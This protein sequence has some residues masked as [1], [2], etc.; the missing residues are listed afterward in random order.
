MSA[1]H[2]VKVVSLAVNLPGPL[3]VSRLAEFGASVIKVEPPQGDPLAQHFPKY[4]KELIGEQNVK[5]LDLKAKHAQFLDLLSDADIFVTASRRNSLDKLGLSWKELHQKLPRLIQISFVS[6]SGKR[7]DEPAHDL[8]F[9][10]E[11][12]FVQPPQMPQTCWADI[13]G[14]QEGV[15]RVFAAL[16]A[17]KQSGEGSLEEIALGE[18][19]NLFSGPIRHKLAGGKMTLLGGAVPEYNLYEASDGWIALAALEPHLKK[20]FEET[21][22]ISLTAASAKKFFKKKPALH[23]EKWGKE[24]EIP[25]S[26][27][28]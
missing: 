13:A 27:V 9:Q 22:K 18:A 2:G 5:K 8:N 12:G 16:A 21:A 14:A 25:I 10:A 23:W 6:F 1:L 7:A 3:C 15:I 28:R 4:Y 24:K 17:R 11:Q 20:R 19:L 26:K